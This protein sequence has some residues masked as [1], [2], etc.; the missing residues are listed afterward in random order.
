MSSLGWIGMRVAMSSR[1][2]YRMV[3]FWYGGM[4]VGSL[5]ISLFVAACCS[6]PTESADVYCLGAFILAVPA[7]CHLMYSSIPQIDLRERFL[8]IARESDGQMVSPSLTN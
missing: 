7:A 6:L 4:V 5:L 2:G 8:E 3:V 1:R